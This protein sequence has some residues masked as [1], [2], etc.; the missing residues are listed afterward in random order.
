[1]I[2]KIYLHMERIREKRGVDK[3]VRFTPNT[4]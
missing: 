1:M 4:A 2:G 3:Q